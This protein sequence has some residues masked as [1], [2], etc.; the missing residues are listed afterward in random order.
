MPWTGIELGLTSWV[1]LLVAG[2][3]LGLDAVS[4]P[5]IMV[6][7]PLVSSTVGGA[8]VGDPGAGLV[9]GVALEVL[10]LPFQPFGAARYPETGPAGLVAGVAFASSSGNALA[11]AAGVLAGWIVGWIGSFTVTGVRRL[12]GRILAPARRLAGE[13]RILER[14]HRAAMALD[15]VRAVLLTGATLLPAIWLARWMADAPPSPVSSAVGVGLLVLVGGSAGAAARE[16]TAHSSRA[17]AALAAGL[18]AGGLWVW[19]T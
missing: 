6:S 11:L 5:Q 13:P 16:A 3:L 9:V 10:A 7:R 15:F 12:N 17:V 19:L 1:V 4:W 14:R 8:L 2:G 18:V